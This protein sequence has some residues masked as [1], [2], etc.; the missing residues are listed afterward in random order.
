MNTLVKFVDPLITGQSMA[1]SFN[2]TPTNIQFFNDVGIQLAWTGSNPIG[3]IGV[4]VSND[5]DPHFPAGPATWTPIQSSPG[6]PITVTP[7]GSA[8]NAYFNLD[9]LAAAYVQVTYTTAG[10][11]SGA[12]TSKLTAKTGA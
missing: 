1:A 12:L 10:G 4:Q 7:G 6:T 8:G 3:T 9:G 5:Y 11:S 2:G